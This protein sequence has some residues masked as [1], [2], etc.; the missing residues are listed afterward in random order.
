MQ[1]PWITPL[2]VRSQRWS[3]PGSNRSPG[4]TDACTTV[5]IHAG[6]PGTRSA[7]PM[8]LI[9]SSTVWSKEF[10]LAVRNQR[11]PPARDAV[12]V[13][14]RSP[15]AHVPLLFV[16]PPG[17][18]VFLG[19][20]P[21]HLAFLL[22]RE[23]VRAPSELGAPRQDAACQT[24]AQ[25]RPRSIA[26]PS[27]RKAPATQVQPAERLQEHAAVLENCV[28]NATL[29]T[30]QRSSHRPQRCRPPTAA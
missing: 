1:H 18:P 7:A 26:L 25:P 3:D 4:E 13:R 17:M 30:S 14:S 23:A 21:C 2:R 15:L 11:I 29:G 22:A 19:H 9:S 12:G 27:R 16:G 24:P 20:D 10:N 8:I 6:R 5:C 28:G